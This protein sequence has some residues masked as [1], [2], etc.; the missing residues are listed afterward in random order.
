MIGEAKKILADTSS[1]AADQT[2]SLLQAAATSELRS[3]ADRVGREVVEE[4]R[5]L[6]KR[7][8]SVHWRSWI[9]ELQA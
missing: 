8:H 2:Y 3:R 5:R 7:E 1:G 4:L 9:R 6:A